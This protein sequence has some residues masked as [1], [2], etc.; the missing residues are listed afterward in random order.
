MNVAS[1]ICGVNSSCCISWR[2]SCAMDRRA[3]LRRLVNERF[4]GNQAELARAL[5]RS[6]SLVW[7]YLSGH[8]EIGEKFAR[9]VERCLGLP[10]FWLDREQER[11]E[12]AHATLA[13]NVDIEREIEELLPAATPQSQGALRRIAQA[14]S[15]GQLT[16]EDLELLEKIAER[17]KRK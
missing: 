16:D 6:P 12:K 11:E 7:Q 9:H 10:R 2:Y 15:E 3:R 5:G 17:F 8:R 14:A 4:G 13:G 1:A